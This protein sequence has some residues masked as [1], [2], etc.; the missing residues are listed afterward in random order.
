MGLKS[1]MVL[2]AIQDFPD[3]YLPLFVDTGEI[4]LDD[5]ISLG[6]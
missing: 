6:E 1:C 2:R 5:P 3:L 4:N